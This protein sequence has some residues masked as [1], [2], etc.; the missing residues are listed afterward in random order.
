MTRTGRE[1]VSLGNARDK[2]TEGSDWAVAMRL[3]DAV[4]EEILE[5]CGE[6]DLVREWVRF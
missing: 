5:R 4:R 1:K 6:P 2:V 3:R